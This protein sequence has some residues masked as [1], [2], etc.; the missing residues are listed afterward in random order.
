MRSAWMY[1]LHLLASGAMTFGV[2]Q[3]IRDIDFNQV[4]FQFL[5]TVLNVFIA[6]LLGGSAELT[7][8]TGLNLFA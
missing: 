6:V 2:L 5:T 3:A 4:W 8:A 1:R 7:G